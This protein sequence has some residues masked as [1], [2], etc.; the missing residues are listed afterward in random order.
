[1]DWAAL[2]A[3]F[4]AI[5]VAN[6]D[7]DLAQRVFQFHQEHGW[8][9]RL[10]LATQPATSGVLEGCCWF[11]LLD[12]PS[13]A[14]DTDT[15]Q[16][17]SRSPVGAEPISVN[18]TCFRIWAPKKKSVEVIV[19]R[20]GQ[21]ESFALS[22]SSGGYFI[23]EFDRIGPFDQYMLRIDH[24]HQRPDPA[25]RYQPGSVHEWSQVMPPSHQFPWTDQGWSGVRKEDLIIYEMHVGA[26]TNEG[27]YQAAIQRLPA[28]VEL[29]VTAVELMP[30]AEAPGRWNWGY[31]GVGLFAPN[32]A[33]GSPNDLRQFVDACHA[34]GLAVL[35]DVVYNHLGPEGNYLNDVA[36]YFSKKHH[37]PWGAAFGYDGPYA[38]NVRRFIIQ[39]A[40]YWIDE[41]HF[42]GLRLDAV[43]FL[44]DDSDRSILADIVTALKNRSHQLGRPVHAIAEANVN[45]PVMLRPQEDGGHGFDAI[46]CDD[47]MHSIYSAT[48]IEQP[49][50]YRPYHGLS[51]VE[52]SLRHGYLY[53]SHQDRT[54][55][56]DAPLDTTAES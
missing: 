10:F 50:T 21:P 7:R 49:L 41:F 6:A 15:G 47:L 19:R 55:H 40:C 32:H 26:F 44:F 8:Q 27:T 37:T 53:H 11:E 2:T 43:H 51:D 30:L 39:N 25:A 5:L 23:G 31:D 48:T 28:L 17:D 56:A 52:L 29:G 24:K 46:W 18:T 4:R 54:A 3:G 12:S 20:E 1:N 34:C 22:K 35:L 9:N 33:Y 42:D 45:D 16:Q 13:P 38:K 36:P 14:D